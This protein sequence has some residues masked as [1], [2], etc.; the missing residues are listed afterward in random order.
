M[1]AVLTF[2]LLLINQPPPKDEAPW[3]GIKEFVT[4]AAAPD[5]KDTPLR[6]LQKERVR[7]RAVA[8]SQIKEV[9][10]IGRWD[11]SYYASFIKLQ[12]TLWENLA[13]VVEKPAD[14]VKCYEMRL[15]AAKEIE[16]FVTTRVAAGNDPPQMLPIA[17][18]NLIDAEIDL[19]KVKAE[20]EKVGKK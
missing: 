3:A 9:M 1:S 2:A 11:P 16:R 12:D 6:K 13:E 14:R 8:V 5:P 20:F 10:E 7:E 19:L 15:G 18:A 4:K 17:R